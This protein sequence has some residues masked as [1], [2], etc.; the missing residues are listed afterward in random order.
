MPSEKNLE[1]NVKLKKNVKKC[2][3]QKISRKVLGLI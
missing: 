1:W 3:P 2:K